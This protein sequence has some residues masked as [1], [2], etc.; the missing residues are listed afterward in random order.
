M[1]SLKHEFKVTDHYY[2]QQP[3]SQFE[4]EEIRFTFRNHSLRFSLVLVYFRKK[5]SISER[6]Y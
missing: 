3:H 5:R 4:T 2:S 1:R 6:G